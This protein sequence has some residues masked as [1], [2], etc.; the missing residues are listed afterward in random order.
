MFTPETIKNESKPT[1]M[2]SCSYRVGKLYK[3]LPNSKLLS[4]ELQITQEQ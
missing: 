2:V 1:E 4:T 3:E